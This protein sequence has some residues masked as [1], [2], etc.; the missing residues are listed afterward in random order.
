MHVQSCLFFDGRCLSQYANLGISSGGRLRK[1]FAEDIRSFS[2]GSRAV[3]V[4]CPSRGIR[5]SVAWIVDLL[6][7]RPISRIREVGSEFGVGIKLLI[8][9]DT[10]G[11]ISDIDPS[12]EMVEQAIFRNAATIGHD[13]VSIC[14]RASERLP[15]DDNSFDK[16]LAISSMQVRA[17]AATGLREMQGLMRAGGRIVLG[18]TPQ[19]AHEIVE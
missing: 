9:S 3:W 11:P 5:R 18:F 19:S 13:S 7:V 4:D 15:F 6:E 16:D 2:G 14:L 1:D 12:T 17:D 8:S 10:K